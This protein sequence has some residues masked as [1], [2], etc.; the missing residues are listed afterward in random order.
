MLKGADTLPVVTKVIVEEPIKDA[1][2][3][4]L[5]KD[6]NSIELEPCRLR[7]YLHLN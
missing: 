3:A 4:P 5:P 7:P 2:A 6:T 1:T